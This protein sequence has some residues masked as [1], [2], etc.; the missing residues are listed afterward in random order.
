MNAQ[1]HMVA[2]R[3]IQRTAKKYARIIDVDDATRADLESEA[4]VELLEGAHTFHPSKGTWEGF[5]LTVAGRVI[6]RALYVLR[7]PVSGNK[8]R[9][10]KWSADLSAEDLLTVISYADT[11]CVDP[12]AWAIGAEF[13]DAL[14]AQ[15]RKL[16]D[17]DWALRVL[18]HDD[19]PEAIAVE[20]G[21]T[22]VRVR[23]VVR[24]ATKQARE[25]LARFGPQQEQ[26]DDERT[27]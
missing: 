4:W 26:Q 2:A 6:R 8:W 1:Q 19:D 24:D 20:H 10:H 13:R 14:V 9:A 27:T 3:V 18:L 11:K 5:V 7:C 25:A 17:G 12:D 15:L 22:V 21:T 16:P 23:A